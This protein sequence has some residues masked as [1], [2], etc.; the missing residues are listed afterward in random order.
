MP[1]L[2]TPLSISVPTVNPIYGEGATHVTLEDEA[3]G[4]YIILRQCDD[5][6]KVG[7]VRFDIEE[8]REV[9]AAAEGL[10]KDWP[11]VLK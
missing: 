10:I 7:E 3:G 4:P 11:E 2:S 5:D 9:L 1:Y 6:S 8:L